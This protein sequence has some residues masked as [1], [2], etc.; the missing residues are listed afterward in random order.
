VRQTCLTVNLLIT[1]VS[2]G[3]VRNVSLWQSAGI[4]FVKIDSVWPED[5]AQFLE[6]SR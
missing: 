4:L 6:E 1:G 5:I 2:A 3:P